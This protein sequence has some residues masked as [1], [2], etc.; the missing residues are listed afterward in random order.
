MPTYVCMYV[1]MYAC[2]CGHFGSSHFAQ[3][4]WGCGWCSVVHCWA[5]P[6]AKGLKASVMR[7]DAP[8]WPAA[9]EAVESSQLWPDTAGSDDACLPFA[10]LLPGVHMVLYPCGLVLPVPIVGPPRRRRKYRRRPVSAT[11]PA[12]GGPSDSD[13]VASACAARP[14]DDLVTKAA[15]AAGLQSLEVMLIGLVGA[16]SLRVQALEAQ[17]RVEGQVV[18]LGGKF[19]ALVAAI[20]SSR[21]DHGCRH[22]FPPQLAET[23]P[24][25]GVA[26]VPK[27]GEVPLA[28]VGPGTVGVKWAD[29]AVEDNVCTITRCAELEVQLVVMQADLVHRG[30]DIAASKAYEKGEPLQ[31]ALCLPEVMQGA[32]LVHRGSTTAANLACEKGE[33][34][35]ISAAGT[36]PSG[37]ST[38]G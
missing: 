16:L 12:Q 31:Q 23:Q 29:I 6:T 4:G 7:A 26:V 3:A 8:A 27:G 1:C 36:W 13:E 28:D 35:Q 38:G 14:V 19:D 17:L 24:P 32:D 10:G 2:I 5:M 37:R 25:A 18:G 11:A 34:L 20:A 30:S 22:G 21:C 9:D 33:P 15:L